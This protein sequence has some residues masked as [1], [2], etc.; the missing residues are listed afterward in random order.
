MSATRTPPPP[1]QAHR[2]DTHTG[3]ARRWGRSPEHLHAHAAVARLQAQCPQV[4]VW[5][6]ETSGC[7]YLMDARGLHIRPSLEGL[8]LLVWWHVHRPHPHTG[9]GR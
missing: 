2:P 8:R 5:Y 6:G 1:G 3:P 9:A 7:Y 4:I